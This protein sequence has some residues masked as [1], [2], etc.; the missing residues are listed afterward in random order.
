M[1]LKE[2]RHVPQPKGS[3]LSLLSPRFQTG[4]PAGPDKSSPAVPVAGAERDGRVHD[5]LRLPRRSGGLQLIIQLYPG[6]AT[7][8]FGVLLESNDRIDP[9]GTVDGPGGRGQILS[10]TADSV[11]GRDAPN[12]FSGR[13]ASPQER[14]GSCQ[15][16][17]RASRAGPLLPKERI[18]VFSRPLQDRGWVLHGAD[19]VCALHRIGF[20]P[21]NVATCVQDRLSEEDSA[22]VWSGQQKSCSAA[23]RC[24]ALRGGDSRRLDPSP[25]SRVK[26]KCPTGTWSIRND[27]H[28]GP[29][30]QPFTGPQWRICSGSQEEPGRHLPLRRLPM[31][32]ARLKGTRKEVVEAVQNG[33]LRSGETAQ[34][35]RRGL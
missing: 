18:S 25:R 29:R 32:G 24:T 9:Q 5:S 8:F 12:S 26:G 19:A 21:L 27:S 7:P 10:G 20:L 31:G 13:R 35:A 28:R 2:N 22:D 4:Q 34:N 33:M 3:G 1:S 23:K 16:A 30:L 14:S 15:A 11:G 17:M 6:K